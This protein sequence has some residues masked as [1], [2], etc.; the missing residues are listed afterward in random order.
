MFIFLFQKFGQNVLNS[1]KILVLE[2]PITPVP[3]GGIFEGMIF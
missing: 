1:P 2:P 3:P